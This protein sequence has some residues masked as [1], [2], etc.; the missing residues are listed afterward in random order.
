M[1]AKEYIKLHHDELIYP[2]ILNRVIQDLMPLRMDKVATGKYMNNHLSSDMF[3]CH[4]L[5]IMLI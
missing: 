4:Y 1:R 2:E 3:R 5:P